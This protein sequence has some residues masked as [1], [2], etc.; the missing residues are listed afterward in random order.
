MYQTH[1]LHGPALQLFHWQYSSLFHQCEAVIPRITLSLLSSMGV[2]RNLKGKLEWAP[3]CLLTLLWF[4]KV[5][6]CCKV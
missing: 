3:L 4:S 1:Y 5:S 6:F 2:I